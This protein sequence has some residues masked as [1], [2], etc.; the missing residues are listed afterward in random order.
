[1]RTQHDTLRETAIEAC[2]A[3]FATCHGMAMDHC[4]ETGGDHAGPRHFRLMIGCAELCRATATLLLGQA[5]H[6]AALARV[7][8]DMC[9]A[10]AVACDR[11]RD[12]PACVAACR[13]CAAACRAT[14]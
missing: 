8:A 12:M 13:A 2:L 5:P 10:C 9:D 11:L 3:C 14:I 4:L 1:M 6:G 7:C